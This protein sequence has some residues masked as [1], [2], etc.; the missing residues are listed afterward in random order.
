MKLGREHDE[1][2]EC[3]LDVVDDVEGPRTRGVRPE[4]AARAMRQRMKVT[5]GQ[6]SSRRMIAKSAIFVQKRFEVR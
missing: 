6:T 5:I 3:Q 4:A 1:Q 2:Q